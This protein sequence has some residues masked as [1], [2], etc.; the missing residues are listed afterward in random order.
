[1]N[2]IE[3]KYKDV[4][5]AFVVCSLSLF[6]SVPRFSYIIIEL[7][8]ASRTNLVWSKMRL[9]LAIQSL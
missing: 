3:K 4:Y 1:M 5:G 9:Y 2:L 8:S 6:V 7:L